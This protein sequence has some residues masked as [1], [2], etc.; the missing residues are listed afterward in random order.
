ME[1]KSGV[2]LDAEFKAMSSDDDKKRVFKEMTALLDALRR[3]E[4]PASIR[5][6]G[7]LSFDGEGNVGQRIANDV[8][9]RSVPNLSSND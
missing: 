4:L 7:G 6:F 2:P 9:L 8:S 1:H 5:G 3:F